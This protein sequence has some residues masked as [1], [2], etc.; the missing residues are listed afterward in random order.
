MFSQGGKGSTGILTNKQAIARHFGVKQSEVV[1][2]SVGVDLGGYKVIYDK[3]TQRA[4]SLPVGIASGTTAVSL[5]TAAVLVHSAGS[6]DL[7]ALAVSREEYVTLPGSFDSGS[8]INVKNELLTYTDGKYRWDGILPKSVA[9]GSTPATAGGEGSGAWMSVG[10]AILRSNLN[11]IYGASFIKG[12]ENQ[13]FKKKTPLT[14]Q[15]GGRTSGFW[16]VVY[17]EVTGMWYQWTGSYPHN[18]AASPTTPQ[19]SYQGWICRGTLNQFPV[20]DPRNF[21]AHS[22]IEFGYQDFDS[23]DAIQLMIDS[24]RFLQDNAG[25]NWNLQFARRGYFNFG[26]FCYNVSRPILVQDDH[27]TGLRASGMRIENG[28]LRALPGFTP[29]VQKKNAAGDTRSI[30]AFF[31]LGAKDY[32][33]Q[34]GQY[35]SYI[36]I[37]DMSFEGNNFACD[38]VV[39]ADVVAHCFMNN[40][41]ATEV[42]YGV[43]GN[44]VSFSQFTNW[45]LVDVNSAVTINNTSVEDGYNS[46]IGIEGG[47]NHFIG[48]TIIGDGFNDQGLNRFHFIYNGEFN[49]S[50]VISY[51]GLGDFL[52][53]SSLAG[54]DTGTQSKWSRLLNCE[55]GDLGGRIMKAD[56]VSNLQ[57]EINAI[58]CGRLLGGAAPLVQITNCDAIDIH[59]NFDQFYDMPSVWREVIEV[60]DSSR[61]NIHQGTIVSIPA[62][63]NLFSMIAF[64]GNSQRCNVAPLSSNIAGHAKMYIFPVSSEA[65]CSAIS[66]IGGSFVEGAFISGTPDLKGV[67]DSYTAVNIGASNVSDSPRASLSLSNTNT[68]VVTFKEQHILKENVSASGAP[69]LSI[70]FLDA[71]KTHCADIEVSIAASTVTGIGSYFGKFKIRF[72]RSIDGSGRANISPAIDAYSD[73]SVSTISISVTETHTQYG[74]VLG[75]LPTFGGTSAESLCNI[76]ANVKANSMY[77]INM[78]Q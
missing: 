18:F 61:V 49:I 8:T 13:F 52:V 76:S 39:W 73:G 44:V 75:V 69:L 68:P 35:V 50:N 6:V 1:Y 33:F 37:Q 60:V 5:S 72:I 41:E 15:A 71:G 17:D 36:K 70:D 25:D 34:S 26:G 29:A 7:G 14:I 40:I 21:G 48:F 12:I 10:D 77:R 58:K 30:S 64:K 62:A 46:G 56:Y 66:V 4:Y 55:V 32:G 65:T 54:G 22:N 45:R 9:A 67:G 20:N 74:I 63:N 3:E 2:F 31:I 23:T 51:N 78:H 28:G 16:E 38:A 27:V 42:K 57:V 43:T 47:G 11:E 24:A 53:V 19:Q 59:P